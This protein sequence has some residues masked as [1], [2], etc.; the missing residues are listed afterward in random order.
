VRKKPNRNAIQDCRL[1]GV[2]RVWRENGLGEGSI[3]NYLRKVRLFSE[4]HRGSTDAHLTRGSADRF[5]QNYVRRY[6]VDA[7]EMRAAV[8]S[9]LRAW[10]WGLAACGV[11]VPPWMPDRPQ[12][13]LST[14]LRAYQTHRRTLRGVRPSSIA[15]EIEDLRGFCAFLKARR[16]RVTF[17]RLEDVDAYVTSLSP[18]FARRTIEHVCHSIRAYLRFLSF[19][20]LIRHDLASSVIGPRCRRSE[21]PPRALPWPDVKAILRAVDRRTSTGR[22]DY[23]LL[24]LMAS[25]GLGSGEARGLLLDDIDWNRGQLRIRRPKTGREIILPLLPEA[26]RALIAYLRNGRPRHTTTR[27]VFVQARA[28]YGALAASSAVRHILV[29]HAQAAGVTGKFLGSHALRHSHATRQI[30]LGTSQTMVGDILGHRSPHSTSAYLSVA[31]GRLRTLA[32][33]VPR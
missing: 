5:S 21:R 6:R 26:S 11:S 2:L 31:L 12:T 19:E 3:D 1:P 23:A 13:T 32:L 15:R 27:T 33:P 24:L 29:K 4:K 14:N 28:P 8:R 7:A 17:P 16:R 10:A 30:E 9:A 20:G 22:R 25:Y 18:R